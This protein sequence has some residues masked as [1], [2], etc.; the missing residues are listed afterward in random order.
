MAISMQDYVIRLRAISKPRGGPEQP[1]WQVAHGLGSGMDGRLPSR[2]SS[3]SR[4]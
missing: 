4:T 2:V 3:G 1:G